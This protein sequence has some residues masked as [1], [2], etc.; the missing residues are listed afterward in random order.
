MQGNDILLRNNELKNDQIFDIADLTNIQQGISGDRS[1]FSLFDDDVTIS[2]LLPS[3][4]LRR[5]D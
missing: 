3:R 4:R 2:H 1:L 5:K